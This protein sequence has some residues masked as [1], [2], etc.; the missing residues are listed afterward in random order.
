[1]AD[2]RR[3]GFEL[4]YQ[5]EN[6]FAVRVRFE[7]CGILERVAQDLVVVDFAVH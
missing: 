2:K 1:M 4:I 5:V 6:D 7:I 3:Y